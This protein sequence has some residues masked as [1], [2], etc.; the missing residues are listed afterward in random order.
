MIS[1]TNAMQFKQTLVAYLPSGSNDWKTLLACSGGDSGPTS[2]ISYWETA[3]QR[4]GRGEK[5]GR[6][7]KKLKRKTLHNKLEGTC[8]NV[9]AY[10]FVMKNGKSLIK[11]KTIEAL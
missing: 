11:S 6:K 4:K 2:D 9:T 10:R 8:S 3:K 5:R 7:K 1:I